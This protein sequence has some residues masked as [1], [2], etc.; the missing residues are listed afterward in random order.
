MSCRSSP[1]SIQGPSVAAGATEGGL[2]SVQFYPIPSA[3]VP[4]GRGSESPK[5]VNTFLH[6]NPL[7]NVALRFIFAVYDNLST[8]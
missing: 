6:T 4:K 5:Y 8:K 7:S 2:I 1:E 3:S